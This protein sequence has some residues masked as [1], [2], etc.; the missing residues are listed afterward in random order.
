MTCEHISYCGVR[1]VKRDCNDFE[2]CETYKYYKKHSPENDEF[3]EIGAI[4]LTSEG[5]EKLLKRYGEDETP[6]G[7][8]AMHLTKEGLEKLF[9]E[10]MEDF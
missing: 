9:K 2:N 7:I 10:D 1:K 3:L 6:L 5:R 8:G 4:N